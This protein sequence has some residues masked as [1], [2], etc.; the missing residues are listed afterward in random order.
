WFAFSP[1]LPP[2]FGQSAPP[3]ETAPATTLTILETELTPKTLNRIEIRRGERKVVLEKSGAGDWTIEGKW[4]TRPHEVEE[5]VRQPTG[6]RSRFT[7][8][9]VNDPAELKNYG[10]DKPPLIVLVKAGDKSYRM[11]L[12]ED[13]TDNNRF[14]RATFLRL[15]EYDGKNYQDRPEIV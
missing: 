5:L 3:P 2:W 1:T 9:A 13:P 14:T 10:L 15:A 12:G 6:L 7:P 8:I 11:V 4:L